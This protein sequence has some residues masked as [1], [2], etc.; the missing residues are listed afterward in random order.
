MTNPIESEP[1]SENSQQETPEQQEM[2]AAL[3]KMAEDMEKEQGQQEG[4]EV[5]PDDE[6]TDENIEEDELGDKEEE[7]L[8]QEREK[9]IREEKEK[10]L[11][12]KLDELF[13]EFEALSSR[14]FGSI[15]RSGKTR[16]GRNVESSSMGE[17]NPEIAKSLAGAFKD[18]VKLL[19]KIIEALPDLLEKFDEDL[20][21][22]ATE[23]VDK[24][25]EE[26]KQKKEGKPEESKPEEQ[27]KASEGETLSDQVRPEINPAEGGNAE[28][29]KS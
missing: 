11:Q 25:L 5:L 29:P 8:E 9:M 3:K 12:E 4:Q 28:I 19:P 23:R 21:R 7:R 18:G 22:E 26:E 15:L 1:S 27:P 14:D 24:K 10:I 2:S 20:T 17:L 6:V 13:K 16:E